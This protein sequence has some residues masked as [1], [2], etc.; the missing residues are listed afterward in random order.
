MIL[1]AVVDII[2]FLDCHYTSQ[3]TNVFVGG[4]DWNPS[5]VTRLKHYRLISTIVKLGTNRWQC[6]ICGAAPVGAAARIVHTGAKMHT[7]QLE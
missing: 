6:S 7:L 4:F 2:Q 5:S 1:W 3:R